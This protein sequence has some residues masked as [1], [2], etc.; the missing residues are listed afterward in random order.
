[1]G[2]AFRKGMGRG[3]VVKKVVLST[4]KDDLPA[5]G[6]KRQVDRGG[7]SPSFGVARCTLLRYKPAV[8]I[9][10][11]VRI[12]SDLFNRMLTLIK[13]LMLNMAT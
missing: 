4:T 11:S 3:D 8:F 12:A 5:R 10:N 13:T 1:M 2:S 6:I 9:F 7:R